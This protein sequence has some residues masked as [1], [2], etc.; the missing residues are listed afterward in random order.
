M[1]T[2]CLRTT[3]SCR[4]TSRSS[5]VTTSVMPLFDKSKKKDT[6]QMVMLRPF[7]FLKRVNC[8]KVSK[9][10]VTIDNML[11]LSTPFVPFNCDLQGFAD[12]VRCHKLQ[13]M[14]QAILWS[15]V[16]VCSP[17]AGN[18]AKD[19]E[20]EDDEQR[21]CDGA[22]DEEER[23]EDGWAQ[24][25][26]SEGKEDGG[27]EGDESEEEEDENASEEDAEEREDNYKGGSEGDEGGANDNDDKNS[28]S[29]KRREECSRATSHHGPSEDD[30]VLYSTHR[31]VR[32]R[33][34]KMKVRR[35]MEEKR[36]QAKLIN[37]QVSKEAYKKSLEAQSAKLAKEKRECP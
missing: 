24:G 26:G 2:R 16:S 9:C 37:F 8:Y 20:D 30:G 10:I 34:R 14:G 3:S 12:I 33:K 21:F 23:L 15:N 36:R 28:G 13:T 4:S 22:K 5:K 27:H 11:R 35:T 18:D 25:D 32:L 17:K 1:V 7:K 31:S 6:S 29:Q 19:T